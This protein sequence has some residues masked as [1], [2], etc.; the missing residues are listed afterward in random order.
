MTVISDIANINP[1]RSIGDRS[2]ATFLGMTDVSSNGV[3]YKAKQTIA[4]ADAK[5]YTYFE[6]GDILV[7]KITPCFEN[8]K[9]AW[10][11]GLYEGLGFG[12]TEFHV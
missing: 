9:T 6:D 12:S 10:V 2:H 3:D 5:G 1:R 4:V 11:H 8:A 7:A